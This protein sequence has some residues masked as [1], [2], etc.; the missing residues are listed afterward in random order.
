M[1]TKLSRQNFDL[2]VAQAG[3]TLTEAQSQEIHA[4][5]ATIEAML[6]RIGDIRPREAEPAL[7]FQAEPRP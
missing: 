7:I 3:L 2:L 1:Q 4:A 6:E 5:Y